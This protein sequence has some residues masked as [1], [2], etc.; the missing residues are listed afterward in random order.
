M[1][2]AVTS[3]LVSTVLGNLNT[4]VL[5]ELGVVFGIQTEFEKLKRTFMTVQ[6]VLK[7]AEEKQWKDEA[8]RIW[9]TDLKDAA[10]DADDVLDE[11]AIEAQRRRQRGGLKNRVRSLFSLHQNPLVF[12][13]KMA[14][15]VKKVTENLD[16]LA[17]EKNKFRL[18]EGVGE[19]EADSFDWRITSSL[20]NESEIY[21]RDKE[22]RRADQF[23]ARQFR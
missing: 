2:E 23:A 20:V 4:L 15:K 16:S 6:A 22:K 19:N 9:L 21:G 12:R 13:L 11:F 3:A 18:T 7:D 1:A 10:Y 8:I 14:H 17:N 5:E